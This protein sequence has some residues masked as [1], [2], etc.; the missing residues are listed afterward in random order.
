M[1]GSVGRSVSAKSQRQS[2]EIN[3]ELG[4]WNGGLFTDNQV[5]TRVLE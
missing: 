5:V 4:L 2:F 3:F 1:N